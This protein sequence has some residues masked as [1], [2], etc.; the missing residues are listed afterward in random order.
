MEDNY[1]LREDY[2]RV[3]ELEE[4]ESMYHD[5]MRGGLEHFIVPASRLSKILKRKIV[6]PGKLEFVNEIKRL[7]VNIEDIYADT[8]TKRR[9]LKEIKKYKNLRCL[10]SMEHPDGRMPLDECEP[11]RIGRAAKNDYYSALR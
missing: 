5:Y 11:Q 2:E 3:L 10:K 6:S 4:V 7:G 1:E 8:E 9:L